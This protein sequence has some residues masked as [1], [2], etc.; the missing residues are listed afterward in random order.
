[1][2]RSW[3]SLIRRHVAPASSLRNRPPSLLSTIA[4]T[5]S[6]AGRGHGDPDL[7]HRPLRQALVAAQLLPGVPAVRR[8]EQPAVRAAAGQHPRDAAHLPDGGVEHAG[9]AGVH[10]DVDRARVFAHEEHVLPG[11]AAVGRPEHAALVVRPEG[12]SEAPRRRRRW[13]PRGAPARRRSG[14]SRAGRR[15][16][17]SCRRRPSCRRRRPRPRFARMQLSPVPT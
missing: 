9:V 10:A 6:G 17:T 3:L 2:P 13:G 15:W 11:V 8:L 5:R 1:M 7:A 12:V 16:P 14:S 4:Q